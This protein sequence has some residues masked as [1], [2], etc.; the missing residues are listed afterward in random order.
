MMRW[1]WGA[2]HRYDLARV[3]KA[4][5][6]ESG[7]IRTFT[8]GKFY[9]LAPC[10][11]DVDIRDIA[12]S[13]ATKARY[14]GMARGMYSVGQHSVIVSQHCGAEHALKGLL[15]DS[16]EAY[17]PFG[18]IPRPVKDELK[19]KQPVLHAYVEGMANR[20][21][22]TVYERFGLS[23][24]EPPEVKAIDD[25]ILWDE[26]RAFM[27]GSLTFM[28]NSEKG[29]GIIIEQWPWQKTEDQF[30]HRFHELMKGTK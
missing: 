30:L 19:R 11:E 18:D 15:H 9:P 12:H 28:P 10:I 24:G 5:V 21:R 7:W 27:N 1:G 4:P 25:A 14:G 13:L 22:D 26:M 23:P 29:L 8:G 6:S 17:S 20:I 2:K 16:D 3:A